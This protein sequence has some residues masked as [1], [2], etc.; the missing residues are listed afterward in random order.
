[1]NKNIA[2]LLLIIGTMIWG[3]A[4][5]AQNIASNY[6]G[7]LSLNAI[8]YILGV[9]VLIPLYLV[10][11][12]NSK[13]TA[14]RKEYLIAGSICGL[15]LFIASY[16][17]QIGVMNTTVGKSG[18]VTSLYVIIVPFLCFFVYRRKL[19]LITLFA[20]ALSV[21]GIYLLC[22]TESFS[23]NIGDFYNF[24]GAIFWA[25]QILVVEKFAKR[26]NGIKFAIYEFSFGALI[27]LV[28][29][30]F[31]EDISLIAIKDAMI[32]LLYLGI[33]SAGV[34]FTAQIICQKYIDA[35]V[36]SIIMSLESVFSVIFGFLILKE[37][38]TSRQIIGCVF[39]FSSVILAQIDPKLIRNLKNINN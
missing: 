38:L 7:P 21:V 22:V 26:L 23:I 6:L 1:M 5:V 15:A 35:T 17:Q 3:A 18:F 8:K 37:L 29:M 31:F 14:T 30:F 32:P 24:I 34:G 4:F 39:V 19:E 10:F 33:L 9:I 27:N 20:T 16:F 28:L 2:T 11:K 13:E 25:V 12:N 36:A